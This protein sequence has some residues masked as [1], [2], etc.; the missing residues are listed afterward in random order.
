MRFLNRTWV[1]GWHAL[2]FNTTAGWIQPHIQKCHFILIDQ[3][4]PTFFYTT[5]QWHFKNILATRW[6]G[7]SGDNGYSI[8][9]CYF[10]YT[11]TYFCSIYC[12]LHTVHI[13]YILIIDYC[14]IKIVQYTVECIMQCSTSLSI[15]CRFL[16]LLF[17]LVYKTFYAKILYLYMYFF[18]CG[19]NNATCWI[20]LS[21]LS[22]ECKVIWQQCSI[23]LQSSNIITI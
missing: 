19:D 22:N 18:S 15:S 11:Y 21:I 4:S 9:L 2:F 8:V 16:K 12:N 14:Y 1:N 23:Q 13:L 17:K 5:D 7:T 6:L 10:Y 20:K 3:G